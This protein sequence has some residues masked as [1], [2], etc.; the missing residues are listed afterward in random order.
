VLIEG[1]EAALPSVKGQYH[2]W[3]RLAQLGAA[4]VGAAIEEHY[5]TTWVVVAVAVLRVKNA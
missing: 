1:P 3:R 4:V 2:Q 5:S